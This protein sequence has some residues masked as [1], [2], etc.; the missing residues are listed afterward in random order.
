M[1]FYQTSV[2]DSHHNYIH[3]IKNIHWDL[4]IVREHSHSF[5]Q[6]VKLPYT[7]M[8]RITSAIH[9]LNQ[10]LWNNWESEN[11]GKTAYNSRC[12]HIAKLWRLVYWSIQNV[13]REHWCNFLRTIPLLLAN[14]KE[15]GLHH[16]TKNVFYACHFPLEQNSTHHIFNAFS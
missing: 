5:D 12:K 7:K 13:I 1:I 9:I 6:K 10:I 3:K 4:T 2:P 11:E 15:M 8:R 16:F 14:D